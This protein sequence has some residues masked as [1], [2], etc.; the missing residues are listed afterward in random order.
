MPQRLAPGKMVLAGDKQG[1]VL[2]SPASGPL[3]V[4]PAQ[5][6]LALASLYRS[7]TSMVHGL[8]AASENMFIAKD[9]GALDC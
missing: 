7:S 2:S 6:F 8:P 3:F 5:T 9:K 1:P 4:F